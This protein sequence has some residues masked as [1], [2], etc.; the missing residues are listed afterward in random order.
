MK[1]IFV[2]NFDEEHQDPDCEHVQTIISS[3]K[4]LHADGKV[5]FILFQLEKVAC[6]HLQGYFELKARTKWNTVFGWFPP[7]VHIEK[8][9]GNAEQNKAYASKDESAIKGTYWEAGSPLNQG[10]RT[11]LQAL[12]QEVKNGARLEDVLLSDTVHIISTPGGTCW[13]P[14]AICLVC[15]DHICECNCV[16]NILFS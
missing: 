3:M 14:F 11:D 5:R 10:E 15:G 4:S 16:R 13:A 1:A 7:G 8:A 12:H 6:L 2:H 9:K